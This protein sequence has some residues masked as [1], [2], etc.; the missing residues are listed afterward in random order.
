MKD[1]TYESVYKN[2]TYDVYSPK[3]S[4]GKT[5]VII[6]AHGGG[7]VGGDKSMV[8]DFASIFASEGFTVIAF[9]YPLAPQ[10]RY[11][12]PIFAVD[13]LIKHLQ[14]NQE[15]LNLDLSK[16]IF[17]GD[18][19]G[20]QIV[21]QYVNTQVN[22]EY[23]LSMAMDQRLSHT[24][25]K[26]MILYCG[27]YRIEDL[28]DS[29][30]KFINFLFGQLGWS[31]LGEKN[32]MKSETV[33]QASVTDHVN[34]YFPPTYLT[35]RNKASFEHSAKGLESK[36]KELKVPVVS[37]FF[38]EEKSLLHEFQ[39]NLESEEGLLVLEDTLSFLKNV[40]GK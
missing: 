7:F 29:D 15:Y 35:D 28:A 32:W 11:P 16:I 17:T 25:I 22:S 14:L 2:N 18:S 5:P 23:G 12:D 36:L 21:S 4:V 19:A 3:A 38:S 31:Y 10:G 33:T 8:S 26:G 1:Q 13:A 34:S 9:N 40:I 39:F 37:R 6:W 24:D 27:I 20:A 30:N